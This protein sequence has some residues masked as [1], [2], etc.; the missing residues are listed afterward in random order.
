MTDQ[1]DESAGPARAGRHPFRRI[2]PRRALPEDVAVPHGRMLVASRRSTRAFEDLPGPTVRVRRE[3]VSLDGQRLTTAPLMRV[4][5]T[6]EELIDSGRAHLVVTANVD[7]I[8]SLREHPELARAYDVAAMRLIDGMPIAFLA[9]ILGARDVHRH[10]GA[11]LL[12]QC[13]AL[14]ADR[15]WRITITGGADEVGRQAVQRLR[16]DHPGAVIHHVPFPVIRSLDDPATDRVVS[17]L[18]AL[19]P[20]IVFLCLGSPKQEKWFLKRRDDLPKAVYVGTGAAVDFAAGT[21]IRA[22]R[23][24]QGMGLEWLWRLGHEPRRMAHR[25]L[26]RGP[27]FLGVA[28]RS[29]KQRKPSEQ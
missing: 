9:R 6:L 1:K 27:R 18:H 7:Q 19:N 15:G 25:Y 20:S 3:E 10:T 13:A 29:W 12:P 17:A 2:S 8:L 23:W 5:E 28:V 24:M 16:H 14:A 4:I 26:V 11:D 22:P 21:K